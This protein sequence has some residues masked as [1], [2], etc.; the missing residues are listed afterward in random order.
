MTAYFDD[1]SRRISRL[2]EV[3]A[4]DGARDLEL[5][6]VRDVTICAMWPG[7]PEDLRLAVHKT[8]LCFGI[9]SLPV[10]AEPADFE[11]WEEGRQRLHRLCSDFHDI[12]HELARRDIYGFSDSPKMPLAVLYATGEEERERMVEAAKLVAGQGARPCQ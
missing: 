11:F 1:M 6:L 2:K 4:Y 7:F 3:D 10:N 5:K 12:F 9:Q 8:V